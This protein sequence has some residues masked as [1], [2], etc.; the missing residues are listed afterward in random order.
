MN[1]TRCVSAGYF[2]LVT[3]VYNSLSLSMSLDL[4]T[5]IT[6]LLSCLRKQASR[7]ARLRPVC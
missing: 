3:Q 2:F 5:D 7:E 4:L 1:V 6:Q